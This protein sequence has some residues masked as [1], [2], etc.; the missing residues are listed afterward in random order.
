MEALNYQ[1]KLYRVSEAPSL[2]SSALL[3]HEADEGSLGPPP[4]QE[5]QQRQDQ[6]EEDATQML[7]E[8]EQEFNDVGCRKTLNFDK[9]SELSRAVSSG[10]ADAVQGVKSRLMTRPIWI[11][12]SRCSRW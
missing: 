10:A 4:P 5:A 6:W 9:L 3:S 8:K 1:R 2:L 11:R 12:S 7:Q